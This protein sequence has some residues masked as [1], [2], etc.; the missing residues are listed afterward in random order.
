MLRFHHINIV[1]SFSARTI[2]I[3]LVMLWCAFPT[4]SAAQSESLSLTPAVIMAKGT[5][6]QG[7][8]QRLTIN[9]NTSD[10][11][12]FDMAAED[13]VV[14][15][16]K[17]VF[18]PAGKTEGSI[19]ATA[20]FSPMEVIAPP[21]TSASVVVTI[22]IPPDTPL[23]AII[24]VFRTKKVMATNQK[25]VGLTASMG[26]LM[27]F[28]LTNNSALASDPV[29]IHPPGEDT[30]LN[31]EDVLTNTGSE[32]IIPKGIVAILNNQGRLVGK[33]SFTIQ[34]LLP[35]EKLSY[36]AEYPGALRSGTYHA[37]ITFAYA[38]KTEIEQANFKIP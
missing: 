11:F 22:T 28:N 21:H 17:R 6:G 5:F 2:L 27:T 38:G 20:V 33:A 29:R 13:V 35:G 9:N 14:R 18:L 32:P 1:H 4:P 36:S 34:R 25:G 8:T 19:A 12:T 7:L 23:R 10:A 16:G 15:N 3:A 31:F 26:T 24:A 37:L 30:N